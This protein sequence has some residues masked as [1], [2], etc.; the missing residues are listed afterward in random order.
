VTG[1]GDEPLVLAFVDPLDEDD[2]QDDDGAPRFVVDPLPAASLEG[3]AG[4]SVHSQNGSLFAVMLEGGGPIEG[5]RLEVGGDALDL[6]TVDGIDV[7]LRTKDAQQLEPR[8]IDVG[9]AKPPIVVELADAYLERVDFRPPPIDPT[10]MFATM[11]RLMS[12]GDARKLNTLIV[13]VRG[14]AKKKG[15][16]TLT[17]AVAGTEA[18]ASVPVRVR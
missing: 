7:A 15:E 5:V 16:G 4:G 14:T 11:Q 8:S 6:F 2:E 13:D 10:D 17:L 9:G 3:T 1:P 12:A 18:E